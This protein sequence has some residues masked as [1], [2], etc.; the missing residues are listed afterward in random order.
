[1]YTSDLVASVQPRRLRVISSL[2]FGCSLVFIG[3]WRNG[4]SAVS[5]EPGRSSQHSKL[6]A[7]KSLGQSRPAGLV[8]KQT[9]TYSLSWLKKCTSDAFFDSFKRMSRPQLVHLMSI[10][11]FAMISDTNSCAVASGR[12][13]SRKP[14]VTT[15]DIPA[16][17]N[18]FLCT[19]WSHLQ[20]IH[21]PI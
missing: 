13:T 21:E 11:E 20:R 5:A 16:P 19:K 14:S 10:S 18:K 4:E 2:S 6:Q 12:S 7:R 1:M 15:S 9:V 17:Q 3:N 8:P